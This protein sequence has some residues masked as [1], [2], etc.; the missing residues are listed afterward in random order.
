[1]KKLPPGEAAKRHA[2]RNHKKNEFRKANNIKTIIV[3]TEKRK[4]E[5]REYAK[6]YRAKR[7]VESGFK[8][9]GEPQRLQQMREYAK[10]ARALAKSQTAEQRLL[11]QKAKAERQERLKVERLA[12]RAAK[13]LLTKTNKIEKQKAMRAINKVN[14]VP[15]IKVVK[16]KAKPQNAKVKKMGKV[17]EAPIPL[18]IRNS[19]TAEKIPLKID[20]RT[21]IY[22][23]PDQDAEAIR[24][25]YLNR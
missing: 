1:M 9:N 11:H 16:P 2:E 15:K 22:I 14:K 7:K 8:P 23:R 12:A 4:A 10:I 25:K 19:S 13:K 18:L 3:L 17:I 24:A 6:E 5:M 20:A 21:T